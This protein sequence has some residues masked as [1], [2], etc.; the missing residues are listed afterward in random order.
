MNQGRT[1]FFPDVNNLISLVLVNKSSR[2]D[3]HICD[4][5]LNINFFF[6]MITKKKTRKNE[7][8]KKVK[9]KVEKNLKKTT[10]T[11]T[12]IKGKLFQ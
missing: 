4:T 3:F 9:P 12:A 8:F 5:I 6:Q 7:D 11:D 2:K 10:T 1:R